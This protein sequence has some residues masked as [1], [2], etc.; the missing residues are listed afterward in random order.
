MIKLTLAGLGE[1]A[2]MPPSHSAYFDLL[3]L[4]H[5]V[6]A[7]AFWAFHKY[8]LICTSGNVVKVWDTIDDLK[9]A[10]NV[11]IHRFVKYFVDVV[12]FEYKCGYI[13]CCK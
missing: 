11:G 3:I 6:N 13:T 2:H 9:R 5:T 12:E 7:E 1:G 10:Y 8:Y 4:T